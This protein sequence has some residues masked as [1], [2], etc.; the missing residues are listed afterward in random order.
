MGWLARRRQRRLA[1]LIWFAQFRDSL[2]NPDELL[3]VL[4]VYAERRP[5]DPLVRPFNVR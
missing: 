3:A 1:G 2:L 4:D 5:D